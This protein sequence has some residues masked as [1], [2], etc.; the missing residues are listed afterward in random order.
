MLRYLEGYVN[1][2]HKK[3]SWDFN[4]V[5]L[6]FRDLPGVR[7]GSNDVGTDEFQSGKKGVYLHTRRYKKSNGPTEGR[8]P[9]RKEIIRSDSIL[10]DYQSRYQRV[11]SVNIDLVKPIQ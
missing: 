5:S 1:R 2:L 9:S 6:F 11:E 7:R 8:V 3:K 4:R 10:S